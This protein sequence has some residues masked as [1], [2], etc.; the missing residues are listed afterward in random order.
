ML[1]LLQGGTLALHPL[2]PNAGSYPGPGVPGANRRPRLIVG[3]PI[4]PE[5]GGSALWAAGGGGGPGG[6]GA[7]G[8]G[9]GK[10]GPGVGVTPAETAVP[11]APPLQRYCTADRLSCAELYTIPAVRKLQH[12]GGALTLAALRAMSRHGHNP[13]APASAFGERGRA[14]ATGGGQGR[15]GAEGVGGGGV[16]EGGFPSPYLAGGVPPRPD[17]DAA[18]GLVYCTGVDEQMSGVGIDVGVCPEAGCGRLSVLVHLLFLSTFSLRLS[19]CPLS[20]SAP[21]LALVTLSCSLGHRV[22]FSTDV[23]EPV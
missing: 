7:G 6:R 16:E 5:G 2:T 15:P 22:L 20:L 18:A 17:P 3:G 13:P 19:R 21:P 10:G 23:K 14:G 1:Q 9:G 8:R 4:A 11:L 12:A